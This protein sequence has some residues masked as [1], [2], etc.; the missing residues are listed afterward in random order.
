MKKILTVFCVL[1]FQLTLAQDVTNYYLIRHAEKDRSNPNNS[2]P[3]LTTEGHQRAR[4]WGVVFEK[5]Q[6]D[7][8]YSTNYLRTIQTAAPTA[9]SQGIEIQFYDPRT[10][11]SD[12]FKET[13]KGQ[14]VLI[15]GHSNTIPDL[16][17]AIL[18]EQQFDNI[19][20]DINSYL[21]VISVIDNKVNS[22]LLT[23]D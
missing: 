11:N 9:E 22:M 19:P 18:G 15:V 23:I 17:N 4:R 16:A 21:F 14:N 10:L 3:E 12:E 1:C 20:D 6:F 13:T 8:V 7:A 5:I 2:N